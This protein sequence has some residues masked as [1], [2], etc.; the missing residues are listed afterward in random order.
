MIKKTV[1]SLIIALFS[2]SSVVMAKEY[3]DIYYTYA[4]NL[5]AKFALPKGASNVPAVV[6][7][8]DDF[9]NWGSEKAALASGY[10][11]RRWI[12]YFTERGYAI[13][14]P[15]RN[16]DNPHAVKGAVEFLSK[17]PKVNKNRIYVISMG[18]AA[19]PTLMAHDSSRKIKK[20]VLIC[21]EPLDDTGYNSF[22]QLLRSY[23]RIHSQI[24]IIGTINESIWRTQIQENMFKLLV[25]YGID[26]QIK[27]YYY[28][29]RWFWFPEHVFMD[30]VMDFLNES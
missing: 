19:L 15:D 22:P 26:T 24:L 13:V 2:F 10:D 9:I 11:L 6:Y 3:Q 27:R 14:I 16:K 4:D 21:P 1:F 7:Y 25:K 29:K 17:H 12:T 23:N 28:R 20:C 18:N 5:K 8:P 30:D